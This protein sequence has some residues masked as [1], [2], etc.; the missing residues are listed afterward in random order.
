MGQSNAVLHSS[1]MFRDTRT[2]EKK[3]KER[4]EK[5]T[6]VVIAVIIVATPH[7][8]DKKAHNLAQGLDL[9]ILIWKANE[10]R[11]HIEEKPR[12]FWV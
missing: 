1:F 5:K 12:I 6:H 10:S 11:G 2:D 9:I 7:A 8:C 4:K 3:T